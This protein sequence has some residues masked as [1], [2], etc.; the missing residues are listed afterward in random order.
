VPLLNPF[1]VYGSNLVPG[2]TGTSTFQSP[3]F[4]SK[5]Q[6][7][8]ASG[9]LFSTASASN[10]ALL[11]GFSQGATLASLQAATGGFFTPPSFNN[12]GRV[13]A[14]TTQEWNLEVQ[15]E[16][17]NNTVITLNYV[18]SH[19]IHET[20]FFNGVNGYCPVS[21]CPNG[22]LGLP[23]TA[24][25]PRFATVSEANTVGISNYNG[26]NA[27][28]QHRFNH[29]LQMQFNYLW[30]HALDEISN[31]GFNPF[32]ADGFG[33][34][35]LNPANNQNFRQ[36]NYGNSDY[37][38]R[39]SLNANYVY[40]LPKGPTEFLK[41]W[42]LSGTFFW[43]TGLPYTVINSAVTGALSADNFGGPAFA[44]YNGPS[45]HQVCR[46]PSGSLDG[47][48]VP[49]I[50]TSYFPD[51]GNA[52]NQLASG[53]MNQTRNQ[54]YGPHYF[55]TDMTIMKYTRI[56]HWETAKFGIGAQFFNLLNH[57]NFAAPENNINSG[58]FGDVLSTVNP[59][60]SILGS[61]L[62]GD[63]STRLIQFTAKFN[64]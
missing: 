42:Q 38:T 44:N 49:C 7:Y 37:D 54:F 60:T 8:F 3:V 24:P 36:F 5:T 27:S 31:G 33:N 1:V 29:G 10:Q 64:F 59:P 40:E 57:P 52:S 39:N 12:P 32:I 43:R 22:W 23:S 53:L 2:E 16:M 55:D 19:G 13:V 63:A 20:A 9:N 15:K 6:P 48:P 14:P 46:G 41:G 50:S 62:G 26:L 28:V 18:G 21:T 47:G 45:D 61:F 4:S 35:I 58:V 34:S 30:G 51:F 17:G 56:P 25:D 11:T